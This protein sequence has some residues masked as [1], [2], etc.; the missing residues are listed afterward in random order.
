MEKAR[1][2]KGAAVKPL[3]GKA[4]PKA[5]AELNKSLDEFRERMV[6]AIDRSQTQA[7]ERL[8]KIESALWKKAQDK[9]QKLDDCHESIQPLTSDLE[10]LK[11]GLEKPSRHTA[12][13]KRI[14]DLSNLL[15]KCQSDL[16]ELEKTKNS[17]EEDQYGKSLPLHILPEV[18]ITDSIL[19]LKVVN[20][21]GGSFEK[22]QLQVEDESGIVEMDV[23]TV[24]AGLQTV[25]LRLSRDLYEVREVGVMF[26]RAG[27]ELSNRLVIELE[28][29]P[30][31]PEPKRVNPRPLDSAVTRFPFPQPLNPLECSQS[32]PFPPSLVLPDFPLYSLHPSS[33]MTAREQKMFTELE[34]F[35]G[36]EFM[37]K[38]REYFLS[39]LR[40]SGGANLDVQEVGDIMSQRLS[41]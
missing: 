16:Q 5:I 19:Q 24:Q 22:V 13:R 34:S 21:K 37:Q 15:E 11:K 7:E 35:W 1:G 40:Q 33:E 20:L 8:K 39:I 23:R 28:D 12:L 29:T 14:D 41:K 36:A 31:L 2:F 9:L 27:R 25:R 26:K 18:T 32:I 3:S 6:T 30:P 38:E 10:T 4:P 17:Y